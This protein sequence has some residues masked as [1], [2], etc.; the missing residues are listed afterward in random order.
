MAVCVIPNDMEQHI[1]EIRV[2]V[3]AVSP[4]AIRPQINFHVAGAWGIVADL[5]DRAAKVRAAFEIG[6]ARVK[7]ADTLPAGR[8]QFAPAQPL[9]LPDGLRQP[10]RGKLFIAQNILAAGLR[11][12]PGI[13]IFRC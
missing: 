9:V 2:A 12:R 4:P 7:N 11:A 13:K 6:K 5:Q 10:F 1:L 8:L 3:M